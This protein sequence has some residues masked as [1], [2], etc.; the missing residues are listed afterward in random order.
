MFEVSQSLMQMSTQLASTK[1]HRD[2]LQNRVDLLRELFNIV[3]FQLLLFY[4]KGEE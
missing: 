1:Q 2:E 4:R 3:T